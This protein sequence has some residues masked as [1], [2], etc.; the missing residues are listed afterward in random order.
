MDRF[1]L[2]CQTGIGLTTGQGSN[3]QVMM[4]YSVDGGRT[5]ADSLW[6][7][8]GAL[9]EYD[10]VGAEWNVKDRIKWL[11]LLVSGLAV[12]YPDTEDKNIIIK[13]DEG[14]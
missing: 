6:D 8:V 10:K 11:Q 3:P 14:K 7:S 2:L 1:R 9:G 4:R 5:W 12:V 13:I